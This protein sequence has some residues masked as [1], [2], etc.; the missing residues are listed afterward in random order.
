MREL[1][2]STNLIPFGSGSDKFVSAGYREE[3]PIERRIERASK[4][5]GLRGVELHYPTMV[6]E[7]NLESVRRALEESGLR[8]SIVTPSLSVEP[9]WMR[10]ALTNSEDRINREGIDRVK[11]SIDIAKELGANQINFWPGLDGHDY[12]FQADHLYIWDRLCDAI[13]ECAEYD[14]EVRI[15]LEYKLKE[16]RAHVALGTIGKVLLAIHSVCKENVGGN[17][18]VG[19]ALMAYEN[20]A[21]SAML[22]HR[23]GKLFHIH[24]NDNYGDWDWDFIAGTVHFYDLLELAF[25]LN[26]V[27]YDGWY[28]LDQY[29]AREDPGQA[30]AYSIKNMNNLIALSARLDRETIL[31]ATREQDYIAVL[32]EVRRNLF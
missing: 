15:C 16:P 18:D 10:G 11:R 1:R 22:L 25:W 12:P 7:D 30:L 17:L 19:H 29:P 24:L 2:W 28:S 20:P 9:R 27:G 32:E 13:R 26:E 4:I 23:E 3:L 31:R 6:N 14:P 8:C 21:E 5:E